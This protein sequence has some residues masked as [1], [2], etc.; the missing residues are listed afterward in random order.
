MADGLTIRVETPF[1]RHSSV[2]KT[3]VEGN[4]KKDTQANIEEN[5]GNVGA[6]VSIQIAKK[7]GYGVAGRI[8]SYTQSY[9]TQNRI[10]FINNVASTVAS[11]AANPYLGAAMLVINTGFSIIDDVVATRNANAQ[12]S[13]MQS[14]IGTSGKKGI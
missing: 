5:S 11:F 2:P 4:E 14:L 10:N 8:G 9:L 1:I 7:I 12:A 13:Y 6:F 3:T